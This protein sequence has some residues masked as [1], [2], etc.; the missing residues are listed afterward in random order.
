MNIEQIREICLG[1]QG[2]SE[3]I[4][5]GDQLCFMVAGKHFCSSRLQ[6]PDKVNLKAPD[7]AFEAQCDRPGITPAPYG[8]ATYKW[9]QVEHVDVLT[10]AEW[11]QFLQMA[12]DTI[13]AKLSKK[14][15]ATLHNPS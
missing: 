15:R 2:T 5:Y 7:E 13:V 1:M 8:G 4:K 6:D 11:E 12:Y 14:L 10:D 3:A 9:I